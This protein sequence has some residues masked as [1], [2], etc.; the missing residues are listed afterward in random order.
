MIKGVLYLLVLHEENKAAVKL[1][2]CLEHLPGFHILKILLH[3][4]ALF[5][6]AYDV[7]VTWDQ[8]PLLK[9]CCSR[10]LICFYK[11]SVDAVDL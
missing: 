10:L 9:R 3:Q 1:R 7:A 5:V 2:L 6:S 8:F 4:T 11:K